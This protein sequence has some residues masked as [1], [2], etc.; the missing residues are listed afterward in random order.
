MIVCGC[1]TLSMCTTVSQA[2]WRA[3]R[4]RGPRCSLRSVATASKFPSASSLTPATWP[5]TLR[6]TSQQVMV[7]I[8]ELHVF[9]FFSPFFSHHVRSTVC[10][11]S[12]STSSCPSPRPLSVQYFSSL[13]GTRLSILFAVVLSSISLVHPFSH[14]PQYVFVISPHHMPAVP[15]QSSPWPAS[16]SLI[17][18]CDRSWSCLCVSLR[19]SIVAL[20]SRVVPFSFPVLPLS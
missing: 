19:T 16:L 5:S 13:V 11:P 20:S 6:A 8:N 14:F 10:W 4:R 2:S 18:E 9:Y 1:R 7:S 15:V 17:L 12:F 3:S